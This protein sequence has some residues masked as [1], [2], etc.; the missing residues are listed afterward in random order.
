MLCT[1]IGKHDDDDG[2]VEWGDSFAFPHPALNAPV[3]DEG[4]WA[5]NKEV[6]LAGDPDPDPDL[7]VGW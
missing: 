1:R 3:V 6:R 7:S 5:K 2:S 4:A